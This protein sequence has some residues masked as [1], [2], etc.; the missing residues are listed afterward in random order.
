MKNI[1]NFLKFDKLLSNQIFSYLY[2]HFQVHKHHFKDFEYL[3]HFQEKTNNF[4][5]LLNRSAK[6]VD[7]YLIGSITTLENILSLVFITIDDLS[8]SYTIISIEDFIKQLY[9]L[10]NLNEYNY[11][12]INDIYTDIEKEEIIINELNNLQSSIF[13]DEYLKES[14]KY[15]KSLDLHLNLN[16]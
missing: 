15:S 3:D 13:D 1:S 6:P 8:C 7:L 12:R 11:Y 2:N 5:T 16:N 10:E 9:S 4:V 14:I